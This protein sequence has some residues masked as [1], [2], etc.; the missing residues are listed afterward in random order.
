MSNGAGLKASRE[1]EIAFLAMEQVLGVDTKLADAGA[2]NKMPDGSWVYHC[3]KRRGP[4]EVTSPPAK[5]L[6]KKW[7]RA[8]GGW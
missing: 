5:G 2:G 7:P 8:K 4:V 6:M 1:E 3:Q